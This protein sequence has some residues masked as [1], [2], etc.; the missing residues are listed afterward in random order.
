M[1][2]RETAFLAL[3]G[4]VIW[5]QGAVTFHFAGA[6]LLEHGLPI[7][8][9][10]GVVVAVSICVLLTTIMGWRKLPAAQSVT[11]AVVMLLPGLFGDVV[12]VLAFNR[13]TGL[14]P[15]SV[16]AF[17]A[18]MLFGTAVLLAFALVRAARS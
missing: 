4:F 18:V 8:A 15:A 3:L 12:Y 6:L 16:G 1:S 9:L 17:A 7:L 14:Q 11:V 13:L 5:L 10:V 2:Q